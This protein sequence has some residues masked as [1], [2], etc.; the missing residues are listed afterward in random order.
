MEKDYI[1]K[2]RDIIVPIVIKHAP[3]VRI[4]L[5]GSR[6]RLDAREGSDVDI[7]LDAGKKIDKLIMNKI[8]DNLEESRLP[9]CFDIVD[10]ASVSQDMQ[11]EIMKDGIIWKE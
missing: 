7:A 9:I 2:Y 1:L 6:A 11:K 4:I 3:T 5:Y 8:I 10:F